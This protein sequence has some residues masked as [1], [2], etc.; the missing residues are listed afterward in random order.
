MGPDEMSILSTNEILRIPQNI[1]EV[2]RER[3]TWTTEL[4]ARVET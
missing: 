4:E 2:G 1:L 3:D